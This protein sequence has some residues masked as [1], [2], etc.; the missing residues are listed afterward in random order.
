MRENSTTGNVY[1]R[2]NLF[3]DRGMTHEDETHFKSELS[4]NPNIANAFE[5]EQNFRDY[6][7][8]SVEKVKASPEMIQTIREKIR[9]ASGH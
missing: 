6:L 8:S 1:Q 7:R 2:V 3:L 4:L 5:K 9:T